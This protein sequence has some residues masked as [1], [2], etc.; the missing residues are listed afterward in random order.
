MKN[1]PWYKLPVRCIV[2]GGRD[3][4]DYQLMC[5]KLDHLFSKK[6]PDDLAII[7]GKAKGADTLA[8]RYTADHD[9]QGF[10]IPADWDKHGK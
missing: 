1:L 4:S 10:F 8:E 7:S 6:D 5:T 2:A 9:L 3:F